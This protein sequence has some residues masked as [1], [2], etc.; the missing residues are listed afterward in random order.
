MEI[1]WAGQGLYLKAKAKDEDTALS[2]KCLKNQDKT[3][4]TRQPKSTV[5]R[6]Q[7]SDWIR[8][9]KNCVH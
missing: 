3:S 9:I 1:R 7:R 4:R 6:M 5:S 2:L 8:K